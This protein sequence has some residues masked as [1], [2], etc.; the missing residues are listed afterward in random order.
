MGFRTDDDVA[1]HEYPQDLDLSYRM[2]VPREALD[3]ALIRAAES[4]GNVTVAR[5]A[6]LRTSRSMRGE[7]AA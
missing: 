3:P 6:R 4:R 7:S 2:C 5:P 1:E